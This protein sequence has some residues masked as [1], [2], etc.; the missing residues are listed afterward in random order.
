MMCERA[1]LGRVLVL[2][3]PREVRVRASVR[4]VHV[5]ARCL[6]QRVLLQLLLLLHSSKRCFLYILFVRDSGM[7]PPLLAAR[8]KGPLVT[9]QCSARTLR[10]CCFSFCCILYSIV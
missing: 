1:G 9:P 2:V 3:R 4:G 8:L 7:V 6:P 5:C 10:S